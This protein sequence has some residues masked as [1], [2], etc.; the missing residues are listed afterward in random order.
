MNTGIIYREELK[1]YDFGPGHPF[2]GDR[3]RI[4]PQFLAQHLKQEGN[5]DFIVAEVAND[6]DLS[7]IC[8]M[9]YVKFTAE[10]FHA[11]HLGKNTDEENFYLYHTGDNHP[12]GRPGNLEHAARIIIGQARK[13]ADLVTAGQ[14]QKAVSIG[15]GMHHAKRNN[16]E[17]FCVY[18]D[19]AFAGKYLVENCR[20]DRVLILDTDAH[21]GNGTSEYFYGDPRV[22][23]IDIHQDPRTIY[24]GTGYAF[25]IGEGDGKGKTVNI[26]MPTC[27][28]DDAYRLVFD[29]I[30]LPVARE[31][32]PQIIVR[33]GGSDPH[34]SDQLT[35]LGLTLKGFHTVGQKVA[36]LAELCAGKEIDL[37]ASGY[38]REILPYAWF[39][40]LAGLMKWDVTL[41]E[42]VTGQEIPAADQSLAATRHVITEVKSHLKPYWHSLR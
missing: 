30:V 26:P 29:E 19:V 32:Q 8:D 16:G 40:L 2:R 20:L 28:G 27:A 1:E 34:F 37:I 5:Y 25:E 38:N 17:G 23:F 22:L 35:Q 12:A 13:A 14:Y 39:S 33:N 42:P 7:L 4:F 11:A 15:G 6:T 9:D 21:A 3:Y 31:F 41:G 18:N 10:Y 24:P 36:E